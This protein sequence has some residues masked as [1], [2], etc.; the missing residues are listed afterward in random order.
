MRSI[1]FRGILSATIALTA[2]CGSTDSVAPVTRPTSAHRAVS[3]DVFGGTN[4]SRSID[5]YVWVSCANG[6]AGETVRVTGDLRYDLNRRQ[7]SSGVFHLSIKSNTSGLTAV[8][9][10]SGT[11]FR[12]LMTEHITS[13]AE[14]YLNMDV[15]TADIIR[16][17]AT[18][19]RDSYSLMVNSRFIVDQGTYVLA[20]QTWKEVCR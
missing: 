18:G 5:Q 17:V 11:F 12:G 2:A 8:G 19:S 16:F 7:D 10:T 6:G 4:V 3:A 14:D 1:I 9:L 15:R 20:E 13:R